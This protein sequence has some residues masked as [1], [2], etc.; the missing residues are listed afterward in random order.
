MS[1]PEL[2]TL[3]RELVMS[4]QITEAEFWDGR[5][6]ILVRECHIFKQLIRSLAPH[7][8][9]VCGRGSEKRQTWPVG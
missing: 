8:R 9:P 3:H 7:P 2:G 6:V 5:E 1:N 4:G